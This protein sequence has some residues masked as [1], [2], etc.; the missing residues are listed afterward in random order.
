MLCE[1]AHLP[2]AVPAQLRG[3]SAE[4]H[5]LVELEVPAEVD[6]ALSSYT[7]RD[8]EPCG[9]CGR[10]NRTLERVVLDRSTPSVEYDIV[11]ARNHPPLLLATERFMEVTRDLKL[12]GIEFVPTE[13]E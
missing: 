5:P 2:C 3:R 8:P 4:R 11:R 9:T 12:V 7:L 10:W 6:L 13:S 1:R